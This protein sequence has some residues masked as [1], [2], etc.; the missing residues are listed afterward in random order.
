MNFFRRSLASLSLASFLLNPMAAYASIIPLANAEQVNIPTLLSASDYGITESATEL[1]A[2]RT[3]RTATFDLGNGK[4][5]QVSVDV[6]LFTKH[7]QY[8]DQIVFASSKGV[9]NGNSFNFDYLPQDTRVSFDLTKP[10]YTLTK[11]EHSFTLSFPTQSS[12]A[13]TVL[14][15]HQVSYPLS[16][17]ATLIW[18]VDGANVKKEIYVHN[19]SLA[20]PTED[21]PKA[22]AGRFPFTIDSDLSKSLQN[23]SII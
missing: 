12:I 13:G 16:E 11:G 19:Q 2:E 18:T 1:P 14:N 5:A 15:D 21:P 3:L 4:R 6:N 8:P 23:N 17:N 10:S 7:P 9:K 22:D 20:L